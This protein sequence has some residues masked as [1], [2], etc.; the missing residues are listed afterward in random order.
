VLRREYNA[1]QLGLPEQLSAATS[2]RGTADANQLD[3]AVERYLA[4]HPGSE[5]HVTVIRLGTRVLSTRDGPSDV[6]EMQQNGTLPVG[7]V[8]R[9]QTIDSPAGPLRVLTADVSSRGRT[10]AQVSVLGPLSPGRDQAQDAFLRIAAAGAVGLVLGGVILLIALRR[11]LRPVEDLATAARSVDLNDLSSR[12]PEPASKDE[13]A[14]MAHE[15]NRM[16]D[17][18]RDDER[19]RRQLLS[20][21]SHELRTPLAVAGG[22]LELLETLG[23]SEGYSAAETAAVVRRELDR[24]AR[25]V[26]DLTAINRG[27]AGARIEPEPV[28]APDV[29][30]ALSSRLA[31]LGLDDVHVSTPP[32]VV[33][34]GNE[35]RLT[36]ALLN[37][38]VNARTHTPPGT[39]VSVD[40]SVGAGPGGRPDDA[41]H[42]QEIT[43][44]VRDSGPGIDPAVRDQA[45]QP[46]V[47]TKSDGSGRTSGL[48]LSVV[49]AIIEALGGRVRLES[50]S[51]GTVVALT[52]PLDTDDSGPAVG[53]PDDER[54]GLASP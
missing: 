34:L 2:G 15:F 9:I 32:P 10:I 37:L 52:L 40:S 1:L 38:V 28:F 30:D 8:G 44:S 16:L 51:T 21:I 46:F 13:V 33:L 12:I 24:L 20:A 7:A 26:D 29:T 39:P 53:S 25:I 27:E 35:D 47:T 3:R 23:P 36:Q 31:G 4:L 19:H 22:H 48:G 11:A 54:A 18:I 50:G 42:A 41:T 49:K 5:Q 45:F 17:R 43:F 6:Q 14:A